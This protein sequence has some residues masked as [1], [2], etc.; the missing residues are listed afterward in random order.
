MTLLLVFIFT[1]PMHGTSRIW[2]RAPFQFH[3]LAIFLDQ[4]I[5]ALTVLADIKIFRCPFRHQ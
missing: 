5:D 4:L 3:A 2:D 1:V